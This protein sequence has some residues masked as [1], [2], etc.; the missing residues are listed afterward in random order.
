MWLVAGL[1]VVLLAVPCGSASAQG[2]GLRADFVW[3]PETI[4]VNQTAVQFTDQSE[5]DP[6]LWQ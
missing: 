1:A 6:V 3:S 4:V 2:S 5:G